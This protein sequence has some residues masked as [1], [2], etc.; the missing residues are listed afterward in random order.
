M[1]E[2]REAV[3]FASYLLLAALL[4][5]GL[6]EPASAA[7]PQIRREQIADDA[8]GE[9]QIDWGLGSEQVAADDVPVDDAAWTNLAPASAYVQA[10]FDWL[11]SNWPSGTSY[12]QLDG[13]DIK[14]ATP[15]HDQFMDDGEIIQLVADSDAIKAAAWVTGD[16]YPRWQLYAS[17]K[18]E[19]G[20]G[21]AAVDT[22][23][24]RA[25][26]ATL[27]TA[28]RFKIDC[29][30]TTGYALE[31]TRDLPSASTDSPVVSIGQANSGDNQAA[32]YITQAGSG[33]GLQLIH[34][35]TGSPVYGVAATVA[36]ESDNTTAM[37]GACSAA[38]GK[39]RGVAGSVVSS[40]NE[41]Y[42]G[43]FDQTKVGKHGDFDERGMAASPRIPAAPSG[44][45]RLGFLDDDKFST[46][47]DAGK[48]YGYYDADGDTGIE[49]EKTADCDQ[50]AGYVAGT[51]RAL[52]SAT[53][54]AVTGEVS[55]TTNFDVA[56]NNGVSGS[57]TMI[58]DCDFD[59][60]EVKYQTI[61]IRGG[62][63]TAVSAESGWTAA[64]LNP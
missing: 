62:I 29:T 55:A 57:Y 50:L 11:D 35:K 59:T 60:H 5:L 40:D 43:H 2:I 52:L 33:A 34:T 26:A 58:T 15:G 49:P 32:A 7:L 23:L 22:S 18:Q 31:V 48:A 9:E 19:W 41:A 53:G 30:E 64:P 4:A 45:A 16:S 25:A 54:L 1:V 46:V 38:T 47:N 24:Y 27:F 13:T 8:I 36:S 37:G 20:P 6:V 42:G 39:T 56:G 17:G 61:T 63:V 51:L 21:S 44:D 28:D 10:V 14:P 3:G 12:W